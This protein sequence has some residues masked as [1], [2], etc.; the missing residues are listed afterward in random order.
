MWHPYQS[1]TSKASSI[2]SSGSSS[3]LS[4][5]ASLY[6]GAPLDNSSSSTNSDNNSTSEKLSHNNQQTPLSIASLLP[7]PSSYD[8][9][10]HNNGDDDDDE[11]EEHHLNPS[12]SGTIPQHSHQQNDYYHQQHHQHLPQYSQHQYQ[13]SYHHSAVFPH[14]Q[15]S[16]FAPYQSQ[17][18][19]ASTVTTA[20]SARSSIGS[21]SGA[22]SGSD[23]VS[24]LSANSSPTYRSPVNNN[25]SVYHQP[26]HHQHHMIHQAPPSHHPL[27]HPHTHHPG[28]YQYFANNAYY[29]GP[30]SLFKQPKQEELDYGFGTNNSSAFPSAIP[31]K[32]ESVESLAYYNNM[33]LSPAMPPHHHHPSHSYSQSHNPFARLSPKE[34]PAS[35]LLVRDNILHQPSSQYDASSSSSFAK[36]KPSLSA[37][38]QT[39]TSP[40][41]SSPPP[42]GT[43]S[44]HNLKTNANPNIRVKLQDMSLWKQFGAIGTEMIITKC[45]RRMFPSLRVSVSGLEASA[46]YLMVV[47]VIPVDDNRY[48]YHNCEWI[49]SGKAEAHFAGRG[50]LHPDSPLS[51][52][53][54]AKQIVSFHKLKLTNNPFDRAGHIILN[55]MHKYVPRLHIIEEGKSISTFVFTDAIFTAVTAYQNELI[56]KLKIEYNPFAKGFRDGQSRKDYRGSVSGKRGSDDE[57]E[58][59]QMLAANSNNNGAKFAKTSG[60]LTAKDLNAKYGSSSVHQQSQQQHQQ[61]HHTFSNVNSYSKLPVA[62]SESNSLNANSLLYDF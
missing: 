45:G 24:D 31:I 47:D 27:S 43:L 49:V 34:K 11:D 23:T 51:G 26:F 10:N 56:T 35:P 28:S 32:S 3:P 7:T 42:L 54:W 19:A 39:Q 38:P 53:Q 48:K 40:S 50:Y 22:S 6:P 14:H 59:G 37:A 2:S 4:S 62:D 21:G 1:S 58:F 52:G 20:N 41:S 33:S 29:Y 8:D 13:H 36:E 60:P 46:K 16:H 15:V 61:Q 57:N 5:E 44:H 12:P 55:S 18:T 17:T 30:D 9:D 25:P